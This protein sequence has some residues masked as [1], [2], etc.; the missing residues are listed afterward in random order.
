MESSVES[1]HLVLQRTDRQ[2]QRDFSVCETRSGRDSVCM[3]TYVCV[4]LTVVEGEV[5]LPRH[6]G[7]DGPDGRV[8]I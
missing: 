6:R 8:R 5:D 1:Y 2:V 4:Y 7:R 3:C